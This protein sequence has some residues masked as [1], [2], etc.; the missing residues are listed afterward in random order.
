L[1]FL[2][3]QLNGLG[4][5]KAVPSGAGARDSLVRRIFKYGP[6]TRHYLE[7]ALTSG[8]PLM[9]G[10]ALFRSGTAYQ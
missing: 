4:S 8:N 6:S 5:R 2:S 9:K 3:F 7:E 10:V 1:L